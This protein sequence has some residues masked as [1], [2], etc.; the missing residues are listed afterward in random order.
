MYERLRY[1]LNRLLAPLDGGSN[2]STQADRESAPELDLSR[3]LKLLTFNIQVGISTSA[4]RHYITRSWQH[5]LPNKSRQENLDK[6]ATLLKAYDLVA[7]Q[8]V[9]GGSLRS[10]F[11][12]QVEYLANE[13]GFPYWYQQLN[14]N[15]GPIA[16][17]S[18]GLLSRYRP[19]QIDEYGLPGRIPGRGVIVAHYGKP[20]DPI[21][22]VIMHLALGDKTQ[23]E[24]LRFVRDLI[25]R[26]Q[27]VVLMGDMNT[28]AEKILH[29]SPLKGS[30]L[31]SL[32][33][34]SHTYPSWRPEKALDHILVSRSLI[35]KRA[36][37][38]A[39]PVSDHLPIALELQLPEGYV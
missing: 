17:H 9:D 26:Y 18:N 11:V 29:E 31:V 3:T 22:L 27:H 21:V 28:H 34:V 33:G 30:G 20:E 23:L 36:G 32:P 5:V 39:F 4:Y 19:L 12:N 8:E 15:F 37:V 13:G 2:A 14:R 38:L 24:Q 35:V 1:R 6:I 7:L 25:D 10:G 16:K